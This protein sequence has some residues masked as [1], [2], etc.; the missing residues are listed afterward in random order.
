MPRKDGSYTWEE[1][2]QA[3]H[4]AAATMRANPDCGQVVCACGL[5][6]PMVPFTGVMHCPLCGHALTFIPK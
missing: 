5:T 2:L 1:F 3:M 6:R 4:A